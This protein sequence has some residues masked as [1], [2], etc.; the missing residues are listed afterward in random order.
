M[1]KVLTQTKI[2]GVFI[3]GTERI[4]RTRKAD[5]KTYDFLIIRFDDE[6]GEGHE[7]R[8]DDGATEDMF[9]KRAEG[10][11][12]VNVYSGRGRDGKEVSYLYAVNFEKDDD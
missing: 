9:P 11:L 5:G 12:I 3:R 1:M 10:K 6:R 8:A 4:S 7:L 2:D